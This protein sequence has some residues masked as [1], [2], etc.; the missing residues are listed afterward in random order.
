[1]TE[2]FK[3]SIINSLKLQILNDTNNEVI[4]LQHLSSFFIVTKLEISTIQY[5]D[6]FKP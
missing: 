3:N 5:E 1:M 6:H 2:T 4:S